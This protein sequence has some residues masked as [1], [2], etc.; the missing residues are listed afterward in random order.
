VDALIAR[1]EATFNRFHPPPAVSPVA[2]RAFLRL[3]DESRGTHFEEF[4]AAP[5]LTEIEGLVRT[6][7]RSYSGNAPSPIHDGD[8]EFAR[9]CYVLCR[10]VRPLHIVETGVGN[11]V[12]TTFILRALAEN[13]LGRLTSIDLPPAG[14]RAEAIGSLVPSSLIGQWELVTGASHRLLPGVL[15]ELGDLQ[16]FVHDSRHTYRYVRRELECV[17]PRLGR[18]AAVV[19]D[20]AERHS[21][22]ANWVEKASPDFSSLIRAKE[23]GSLIGAALFFAPI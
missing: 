7:Q 16:M 11:G 14:V 23:K 2:L 17:S 12:S 19:V 20:D 6:R 8:L 1:L 22:F 9:T 21:A 4:L 3:V 15:H 10:I 13:G 5:P 18:P